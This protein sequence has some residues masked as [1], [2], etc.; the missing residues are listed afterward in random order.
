MR[1][2]YGAF[3]LL[4]L[5]ACTVHVKNG[6]PSNPPPP[7]PPAPVAA[8]PAAPPPAPAPAPAP[9]STP[10]PANT[11]GGVVGAPST[12]GYDPLPPNQPPVVEPPPPPIAKPVPVAPNVV[13]GQPPNLKPGAPAAYWIW[14]DAGGWHL[15]TTTKK[16]LHHFQGKIS[17]AITSVTP[18]RIEM[19]DRLK[20]SSSWILFAF[21]T[22]GNMDGFDW[23]M[24]GCG[25][26][27]LQHTNNKAVYVG[28]GEAQPAGSH[29]T[30]C[31]Q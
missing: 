13:M 8:A 9:I 14:R 29:F 18:V 30:L 4:F 31:P 5:S 11:T 23:Q 6:P 21:D 24:N 3:A 28:S 2:A 17:G 15:R 26:F 25:T 10:A 16:L 7:P 27:N 19:K 12:P 22:A 1:K 20:S